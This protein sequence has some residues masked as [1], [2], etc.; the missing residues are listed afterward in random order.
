MA[1]SQGPLT[2]LI[3]GS[4]PTYKFG[5]QKH[6]KKVR[7]V[8]WILL[9]LGILGIIISLIL[10]SNID[11][12]ASIITIIIS[13][14]F[15]LSSLISLL[16]IF[17]RKFYN[18]FIY[19]LA[20][21]V[22][23]FVFKRNH[24]PGASYIMF[25]GFTLSAIGFCLLSFI[26]LFAIRDNKFLRNFGFSINLIL[27]LSFLGGLF[28][29]Q[30][31]PYG[32]V[33]IALSSLLFLISVLSLVFT[34]PNSNYQEWTSFHKKFFYRAILIPMIFIFIT[35]TLTFVFPDKWDSVVYDNQSKDYWG[36]NEIELFD[37][38]GIEK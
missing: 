33:M 25:A 29:V 35:S 7:K 23:G 37:K 38:E 28:K 20:I 32:N 26:S 3:F 11:S 24:W 34:L 5:E 18:T 8:S 36:M 21:V 16:F 12:V 6:S 13:L 4:N 19:L 30:H 15:I 14:I 10:Y 17:N 22:I 2:K 1:K 9:V 27:T 31:W